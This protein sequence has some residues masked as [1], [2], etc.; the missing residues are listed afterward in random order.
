[1]LLSEFIERTNYYP[2]PSEYAE[3]E[4]A[5]NNSDLDKDKFCA[6]W[7]IVNADLQAWQEAQRKRC[8]DIKRKLFARVCILT[9]DIK[10]RR[11]FAETESDWNE[12]YR[13]E[14]E[15]KETDKAAHYASGDIYSPW[16]CAGVNYE[17]KTL[18]L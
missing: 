15:L 10:T 2:A 13:L 8:A 18:V 17:Y 1:M 5:Y 11:R 9:N 4:R 6:C 7:L 14:T 3:I 16:K 12:V